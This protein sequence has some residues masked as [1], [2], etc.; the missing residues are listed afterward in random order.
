MEKKAK[1]KKENE[2]I[3]KAM[4]GQAEA[5]QK[6]KA[7]VT[8]VEKINQKL[9]KAGVAVQ[10]ATKD[11]PKE[12]VCEAT[13][14]RV[15]IVD[16]ANKAPKPDSRAALMAE[17]QKRGIKYFRIL[18]KEELI[19]VLRPGIVDAGINIITTAAKIRWQVG[20]GRKGGQAVG[21]TKGTSNL[22]PGAVLHLQPA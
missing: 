1:A 13:A 3:K 11:T 22:K 21:S 10:F 7:S 17:A 2:A 20:W 5:K 12:A 16:Q 18:N 14:T 4:R 8:P 15:G 9:T 6:K 19:E